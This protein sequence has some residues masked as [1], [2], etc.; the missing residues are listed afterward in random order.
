MTRPDSTT[1]IE[2]ARLAG[3]VSA[4][5]MNVEPFERERARLVAHSS[6]GMSGP[7]RFTYSEPEI[8]T[9][10]RLS[11]P[12]AESAVVFGVPYPARPPRESGPLVA[13]FAIEDR[14]EAVRA[15]AAS[16]ADSLQATGARAEILIDDNRLVDRGAAIRSGVG[17]R[18][19]STMVLT[20]A[21]GP[22]MLL[23][24]VITDLELETTE[25]MRRD[26]G[27]CIAC[28]P[29]CPTGAITDDGL[30]ARL[31]ISTWL[32]SPGSLPRWIRPIIGRRIYGCDDCLVSCPPG[33][34][35][36]AE[37]ADDRPQLTFSEL[38]GLSDDGLLGRFSW[39]YVPR[40]DGRFIRRNLLVAA[41]NSEEQTALEPIRA[42]LR[43]PSSMIRGHAYWALGRF[44]GEEALPQLA[45]LLQVETVAE[46]IEELEYAVE[47]IRHE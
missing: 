9:N 14:Y 34:K 13:G 45:N 3:A 26:C 20:P 12:W 25:P 28:I 21:V 7:L 47:M 37:R 33:A 46:A 24:S 42:H 40:R 10:I 22:W 27:T 2:V 38:L 44:L 35:M 29:A 41:G 30:D 23:G 4:G 39:W 1:L 8:A 11:F 31:C 6:E 16:V 15:V 17:W 43:H 19:K 36:L 32:Q 18:G 5:V